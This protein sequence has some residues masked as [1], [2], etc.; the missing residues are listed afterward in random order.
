L[1]AGKDACPANAGMAVED[2]RRVN[3]PCREDRYFAGFLG[4]V[5]A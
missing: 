4:V 1:A 3:C 5:P 2:W